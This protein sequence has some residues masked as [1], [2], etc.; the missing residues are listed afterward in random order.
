MRGKII[1]IDKNLH[2]WLLPAVMLPVWIILYLNLK[3]LTDF[4]IEHIFSMTP[5]T[6][7]TE[8]IRFF[9][10]E[11][12]KV[13]LLLVLI[14]FGVGIIRTW[15]TPEKTRD[16][17]E[18]KSLFTGNILASLLGIVTPFCSCSAI[19]LFLGFVEAGVPLGVTFSFLIAAPMI[20]EVALVLLIGMFGWKVAA[21]Y[22]G[23]GLMIAIISGLI[24]GKLRLEKYVAEWVYQ[25]KANR[26]E[27]GETRLS[28]RERIQAGFDT[29]K[30][31]VGKI[32]VYILLG[33]GVGA[34][35]HGYVP[36]DFLG[37]LLGKGNW[38]GVP[39][40]ILLGFPMYSN[41]AG[42]IPIV[43]VLIDKGVSLGTAL[44]FMMSVIALSLPEMIILKKVLKWQLISVF[45]GIVAVGIVIVGFVFNYIM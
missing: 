13:M 23:T 1:S 27:N 3:P 17:L 14:I 5:G 16:I 2:G 33:I 45:I 39:L 42:I 15:F 35:A 24:I 8:T 6:H 21:I 20:N 44:A 4:V 28:F 38:Y 22:V 29:V 31:I 30:E 43:S 41:A 7:L 18:G 10:F 37:S 11:V 19:P 9:I 25:V 32:W 26:D 34:A 12:P 40:A 36:A